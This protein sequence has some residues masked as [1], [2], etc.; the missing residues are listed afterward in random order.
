M[1]SSGA[2]ADDSCIEVVQAMQLSKKYKFVIFKKSD[3]TTSIV[4]DQTSE[5]G[6]W[7]D[8]CNA[9]PDDQGRYGVFDFEYKINTGAE[10]KKLVFIL[11]NPDNAKP[12]EKMWYTTSKSAIRSKL[13][14]VKQD[15]QATDRDELDENDILDRI[16]KGLTN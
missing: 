11:W 6:T 13:S 12:T 1:T 2:K 3:D 10:R 7:A 14:A 16:S 15:V 8:F 4:I 5:S 9:L